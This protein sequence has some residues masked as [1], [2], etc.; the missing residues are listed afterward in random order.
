MRAAIVSR[1]ATAV[2]SLIVC[3][4]GDVD[5][6]VTVGDAVGVARSGGMSQSSTTGGFGNP[7]ASHM[8]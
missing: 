5:R 2:R 8:R 4:A 3:T 6:D 7:A 1:A